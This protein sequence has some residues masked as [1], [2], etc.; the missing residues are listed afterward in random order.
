MGA[1]R[2]RNLN[3]RIQLENKTAVLNE[4]ETKQLATTM[5]RMTSTGLDRSEAYKSLTEVDTPFV[6]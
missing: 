3:A 2:L 6:S 1:K 5:G 4:E